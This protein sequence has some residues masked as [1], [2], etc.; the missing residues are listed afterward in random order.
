VTRRG[1]RA[2]LLW[3]RGSGDH[4]S[5]RGL[6]EQAADRDLEQ[7]DATLVRVGLERLET[8]ERLV[9]EDLVALGEPGSCRPR[10]TASVLAGEQAA[11]EREVRQ[12]AEAEPLAD[13]QQILL[14]IPVQER[15]AVLG[16]DGP[17]PAV[18]TCESVD[19][20]HLRGFEVRVP[21]VA[22][23]SLADELVERAERLRER[24]HAV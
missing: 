22:H 5:D 15:V 19:L 8:V 1:V 4:R 21:E 13:G 12:D 10:L 14:W 9:G 17:R 24:R 3:L 7:R 6:P 23:L 16:T 20:R 18:L 11:G 2:H